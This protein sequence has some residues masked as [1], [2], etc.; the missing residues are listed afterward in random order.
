MST[1]ALG[2]VGMVEPS[3]WVRTMLGGTADAELG[4]RGGVEG[5][6][7]AGWVRSGVGGCD[8]GPSRGATSAGREIEG[9]GREGGVGRDLGLRPWAAPHLTLDPEVHE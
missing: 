5:G 8:I 2:W 3:M 7:V 4:A 1:S 6:L 9:G